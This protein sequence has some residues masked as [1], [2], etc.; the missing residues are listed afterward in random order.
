MPQENSWPYLLS[1]RSQNKLPLYA[2]IPVLIFDLREVEAFPL[3]TS[4]A[5]LSLNA[6]C[7]RLG[8]APLEDG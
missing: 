1:P 5:G 7:K 8:E 6:H 3:P 4:V 2:L